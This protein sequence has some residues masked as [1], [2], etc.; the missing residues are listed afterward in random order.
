MG[1]SQRR[2]GAKGVFDALRRGFSNQSLVAPNFAQ[3]RGDTIYEVTD[4]NIFCW[5]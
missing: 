4:V 2:D 3:K 5:K 1:C